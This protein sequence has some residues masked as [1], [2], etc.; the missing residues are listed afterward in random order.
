[1]SEN[2]L[3]TTVLLDEHR[4]AGARIVPFAGWEMPVQYA[5]LTPEVNAV[6]ED[7]G[8][9]DVSHMAQFDISGPEATA[10]INAVVSADWSKVAV[11]RV[12]YALLLNENGGV[13]DDLMGYHLAED[14]WLIV[15]NASRADVDEPHLRKYLGGL[16][17]SNRYE[18]QAMLA[19]QGP[20]S[21]EILQPLCDI[22][23]HEMRWRDCRPAVVNGSQV[24]VARGGYTGSDGFEIMLAG[25]EAPALWRVLLEAGA[26]P[27]G[28]G[29]RDVL[30]LEAGLPLYG[31]EMREE[32][33]AAE[34][35]ASW[36]VKGEKGDFVGREAVLQNA[37]EP[38]A[39]KIAA[40]KMDGKAIAREGYTV[41]LAGEEI[42]FVTS[43]TL[44]PTAGPIALAMLPA[45]LQVGDKVDV[46]I[47]G[48]AHAATIVTRPFVPHA[49]RPSG[50]APEVKSP[51]ATLT[52]E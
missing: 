45:S 19:L 48:A 49:A 32:W 4:A 13:I 43:G 10:K 50:K 27:C 51:S 8:L 6:R 21:Q 30:R 47:R 7:A 37:V 5:G 42:G 15:A 26:A 11:G 35:G 39:Q 3:L 41:T 16:S 12:A 18:N 9:F 22:D 14:E 25:D 23:L 38:P 36:A 31:H 24:L 46:L 28:L 52:T 34:S 44:S 33:S 20:L 1:M 29:A 17:F 40:L 2:T